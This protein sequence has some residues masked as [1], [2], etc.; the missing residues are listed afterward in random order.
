MEDCEPPATES[1]THNGLQTVEAHESRWDGTDKAYRTEA[2]FSRKPKHREL[3]H[4]KDHSREH[5][6]LTINEAWR[7]ACEP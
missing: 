5:V 4:H 1:E 7:G 3:N 6:D 2:E